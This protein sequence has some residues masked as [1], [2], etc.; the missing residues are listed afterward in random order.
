MSDEFV[1]YNGLRMIKDWPERIQAAQLE[2]FYSING[3]QHPRI[4]YGDE[5][6][7]WGADRPCHDCS[8]IKGQFHVIGC[9]V[10]RCPVCGGQALCCG[11]GYD[12]SDVS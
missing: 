10:E 5:K 8:V 4:R 3:S 9:D 12:E 1:I 11:C 6:D 2:P 7:D